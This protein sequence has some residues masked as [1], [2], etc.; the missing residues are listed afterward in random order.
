MLEH[1]RPA[2]LV[3]KHP[4]CVNTNTRKPTAFSTAEC[5]QADDAKAMKGRESRRNAD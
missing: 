5:K 3:C 1:P 4:Q 2:R